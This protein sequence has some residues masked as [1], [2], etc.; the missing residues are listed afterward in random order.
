MIFN[1]HFQAKHIPGKLNTVADF[2]TLSATTGPSGGTMAGFALASAPTFTIMDRVAF[3]RFQAHMAPNT[4]RVYRRALDLYNLIINTFTPGHRA[5]PLS[6]L[7]MV[8]FIAH[9]Q[10]KGLASAT[11]VS[12][13]SAISFFHKVAVWPNPTSHYLVRKILIGA[14]KLTGSTDSRLPITLPLLMDIVQ[15]S[16]NL[17]G[18]P[19]VGHMLAAMYML[20]FFA[21][22]YMW[23]SFSNYI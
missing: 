18:D 1:V 4:R 14:H 9:L 2:I 5:L 19:Y 6:P 22:F 16:F 3:K 20:A 23:A 11:I 12:Y 17:C 8:W 7:Q 13:V 10:L 15:V 21:F